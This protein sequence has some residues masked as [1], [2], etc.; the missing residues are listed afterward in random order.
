MRNG[1]T[2]QLYRVLPVL[3]VLSLALLCTSRANAQTDP[4]NVR[5]TCTGTTVCTTNTSPNVVVTT[6]TLPTL[7]FDNNGASV[8]GEAYLVVFVPNTTDSFTVTYGASSTSATVTLLGSMTT[9]ENFDTQ[10]L[11]GVD[12]TSAGTNPNFSNLSSFSALAGVTATSY[13]VY[14]VDLG[15]FTTGT[16][17]TIT[18]GGSPLPLGTYIWGIVTDGQCTVSSGQLSSCGTSDALL[19]TSA[20]SA[21]ITIVPEPGTLALVGSA[22]LLLGISIRRKLPKVEDEEP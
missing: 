11:N 5:L 22:L 7:S 6:S 14:L 3:G 9:G 15:S 20:L 10:F 8:T 21:G 18:F 17:I 13:N 19:D 1:W 16:P 4:A 2:R 12:T